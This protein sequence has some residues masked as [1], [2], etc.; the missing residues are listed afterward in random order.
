MDI[1]VNPADRKRLER[2]WSRSLVNKD[3]VTLT[4]DEKVAVPVIMAKMEDGSLIEWT[5]GM[6]NVRSFLKHGY[7]RIIK[8]CPYQIG[9]CRGEK[10]QLFQVRNGTGDCAHNWTAIGLW[11]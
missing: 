6:A 1:R 9:K 11:K 10:C 3:A 7:V 8:D 4:V 2:L 5:R